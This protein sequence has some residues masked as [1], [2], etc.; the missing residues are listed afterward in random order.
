MEV[1]EYSADKGSSKYVV[2]K[3]YSRASG[4][5]MYFLGGF[6]AFLYY[7]QHAA[8]FS[9]GLMGLLKA[10]VWPAILV[11]HLFAFLKL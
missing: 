4:G 1:K 6:G 2:M 10:F 5:G 3:N 9:D 11:Y 7:L 8:T